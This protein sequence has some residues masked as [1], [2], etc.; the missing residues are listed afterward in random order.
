MPTFIQI[1]KSLILQAVIIVIVFNG[2]SALRE[3]AML[4]SWGKE[5]APDF[6]LTTL[7]SNIVDL[8]QAMG[9]R[10]TVLYFFAPWCSICKYSIGNLQSL[11]EKHPGEQ[12]QIY[13]I[14]LDYVDVHEVE[15][16]V[17]GLDLTMP[18]LLGNESLKQAYQVSAYPSY[19][20]LDGQ[21][22]VVHRSMGYSTELGLKLRAL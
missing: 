11:Y 19:Y 20:V 4:S 15:T 13:A 6:H 3:S 22:Q 10:K 1:I 21:Q 14:A 8:N 5:Q 2:V 16:F 9:S 12:V 7:N 18:V 17:E